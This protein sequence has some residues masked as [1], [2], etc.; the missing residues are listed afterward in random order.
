M[1]YLRND[2]RLFDCNKKF[3]PKSTFNPKNKDVIIK[4]YV[5]SFEEKLLDIHI[6][7]DNFNNLSKWE[8][9][10]LW[11][12]KNYNSI[13]IKGAAKSFEIVVWDRK[14][15]LKKCISI[16]QMMRLGGGNQ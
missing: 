8:R 10:N 3:R 7:K 5:S 11:S 2:E 1:C 14:D 15:Y 6:P 13:V 12:L 16:Y 4:T 9:D